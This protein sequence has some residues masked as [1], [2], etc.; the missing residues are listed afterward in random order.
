M[1]QMFSLEL[2]EDIKIRI[3]YFFKYRYCIGSLT[4]YKNRLKI[5]VV[6]NVYVITEASYYYIFHTKKNEI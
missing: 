1:T 6:R 2:L 5:I 3:Y 4:R